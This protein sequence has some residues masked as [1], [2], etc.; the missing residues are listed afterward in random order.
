[1]AK[2]TLTAEFKSHDI[3]RGLQRELLS[4]K[5]HSNEIYYHHEIDSVDSSLPSSSTSSAP[6]VTT[7]QQPIEAPKPSTPS[8]TP[9]SC[10]A[11]TAPPSLP[12]IPVS[13]SDTAPTLISFTLKKPRH[14]ISLDQSVKQLCGGKFT[15][16][17]LSRKQVVHFRG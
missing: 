7:S 5:K 11:S 16:P 10:T 3:A 6:A 2:K 8:T 13:P 17:K 1:M 14:E 12:D 15:F 9:P 4:F